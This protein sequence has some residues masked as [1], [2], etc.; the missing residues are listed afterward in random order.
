MKHIA[1]LFDLQMNFFR[2]FF[3]IFW[4]KLNNHY[5]LQQF[6]NLLAQKKICKKVKNFYAYDD[7]FKTNI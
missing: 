7:L 5:S 6:Y 3:I 2:L 1:G 4:G